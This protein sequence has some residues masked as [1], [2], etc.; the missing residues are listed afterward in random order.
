[1]IDKLNGERS[2]QGCYYILTGKKSG[3]AIQDTTLFG[4]QNWYGALPHLERSSFDSC[5]QQLKQENKVVSVDA[6]KASYVTIQPAYYADVIQQWKSLDL[7]QRSGLQSTSLPATQVFTFWRR[8]QLWMQVCSHHINEHASFQPIVSDL[9]SKMWVKEKWRRTQ[10][11]VEGIRRFKGALRDVFEQCTDPLFPSLCV[12]RLTGYGVAGRTFQQ[13]EQLYD[14]PE[15]VLRLFWLQGARECMQH[16]K[17]HPDLQPFAKVEEGDGV[18][19]DKHVGLT[20]SAFETLK[21]LDQGFD[22]QAIAYKRGLKVST[23]E[24]HVVEIASKNPSFS[25]QPFLPSEVLE[26]ILNVSQKLK[27]KKL[28]VIKTELGSQV[29][30]LQIRLALVKEA[31]R[32]VHKPIS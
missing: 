26:R 13:L 7:A 10:D 32:H 31:I 20:L 17:S 30:Y 22:L 8:L 19:K 1:M 18:L 11:K 28:S 24:D 14:L 4:F 23:I 5:V 21:Y 15:A 2:V 6:S 3:Q 16:A 25:V 29:T 27:T 12:S 9:E